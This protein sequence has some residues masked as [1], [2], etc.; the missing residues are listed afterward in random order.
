MR[1]MNTRNTRAKGMGYLISRIRKKLMQTTGGDA[2]VALRMER[3][4]A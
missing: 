1:Q 2:K 3:K 4:E